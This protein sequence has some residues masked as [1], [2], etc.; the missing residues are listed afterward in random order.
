MKDTQKSGK[1]LDLEVA[2]AY[3][4]GD[5]EFLSEMAVI[6]LQDYPRLIDEARASILQNDCSGLERAAH[7]MKGRLAFFGITQGRKEMMELE[8]MGRNH[9]MA[10][11]AQLMAEAEAGMKSI[12]PELESLVREHSK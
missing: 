9:D 5:L 11:A 7:T 3:V 12:I 2:L 1:V 10:R 4:G 8:M 6:F